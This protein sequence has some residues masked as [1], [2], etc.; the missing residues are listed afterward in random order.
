MS[1]S[2]IDLPLVP[3]SACIEPSKNL[4]IEATGSQPTPHRGGKHF[5]NR[6]RPRVMHVIAPKSPKPP[7]DPLFNYFQK[8]A[9]RKEDASC[10]F[11]LWGSEKSESSITWAVD[12]PIT[13][14]KGEDEIFASLANR[15]YTERGFLRKYFLFRSF[16]RLKPV[17]VRCNYSIA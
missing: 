2:I 15:Y 9:E 6:I 4:A 10:V 13:H 17:T 11:L 12:V 5:K 16:S 14:L 8:E 1:T 7:E 3:E